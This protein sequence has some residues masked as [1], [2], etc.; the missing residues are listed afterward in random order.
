[1]QLGMVGSTQRSTRRAGSRCDGVDIFSDAAVSTDQWEEDAVAV[2][3]ERE[4]LSP[5]SVVKQS[6]ITNNNTYTLR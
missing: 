5:S 1:M 2:L 3:T 6:K 4:N